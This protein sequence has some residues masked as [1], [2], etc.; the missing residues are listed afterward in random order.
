MIEYRREIDGLRAIAVL[1]VILFHAGFQ[2]FRGG[3]VG[4]DVFFVISGYLISTIILTELELGKFSIFNFYERR[5]R[6]I[7]P[8]LFFFIILATPVVLLAQP[9]HALKQYSE[10]ILSTLLYVSNIFF[11]LKTDYFHDFS[12]S[13]PLLHTWSLAVEEQFYV[14]FP[15][16]L[17]LLRKA[18]LTN[19]FI[20]TI[21]LCAL[22]LYASQYYLEQNPL[23]SF[24]MMPTRFWELGAGALLSMSTRMIP[25]I[26]NVVSIQISSFLSAFGIL[27]VVIPMLI[28]SKVTPFPGV[29]AVAPV[30]GTALILHFT[31]SPNM[32]KKVL[33][34]RILV[35]IGLISYSLYLSHNIVFTIVRSFGWNFQLFLIRLCSITLSFLL[36]I[37][38]FHYIEQ[39]FRNKRTISRIVFL[40]SILISILGLALVGYAGYWSDGFKDFIFSRLD[41]S[42]KSL[43]L[44][45]KREFSDRQ[46]LWSSILVG[47][48]RSFDS[49]YNDGR[50][51][52]LGDSKSED[53]YVSYAVKPLDEEMQVRRMRLEPG[54]M[55]YSVSVY[56]SK[57]CSTE[58]DNVLASKLLRDAHTVLL[59][60][61]WG[62]QSNEGVVAFVR[63]LI[64]LGKRVKVLST[65]NFNDVSSLSYVIA[66]DHL[67]QDQEARYL[68]ENIRSEASRQSDDLRRR[69]LGAGLSVGLIEKL[70]AFCELSRSKCFLR[71]DKG[72]YIYDSGHL[73]VRGAYFLNGL[74]DRNQWFR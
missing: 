20:T 35:S 73:T 37:L 18:N 25:T 28:Y 44:D 5:A 27:L 65:A 31:N 16:L 26:N 40:T 17:V 22:S 53:L 72:W 6:R 15:M 61:T 60:G 9:P 47:S 13:A 2:A 41:Q 50:F 12:E 24:Y 19:I 32:V 55:G 70:D 62:W 4:V 46:K 1:P 57:S 10:S 7:L 74:F 51:L 54:C 68:F 64:E 69:I 43:V 33:S 71:D 66:K 52:I 29:Y 45:Y 63:K 30:I 67:G 59:T 8:A 21:V 39:P 34:S 11:Y 3:F 36:A 56:Q 42:Q 48:E 38:S 58:L 23:F 14:L 49:T